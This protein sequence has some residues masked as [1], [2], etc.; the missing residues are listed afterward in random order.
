MNI[1]GYTD[2]LSYRPGETVHARFSTTAESFTARLVRLF[3][4][5][6]HPLGPGVDIR[7]VASPLDGQPAYPGRVQPIRA[8]SCLEIAESP[9]DGAGVHL[10]FWARPTLI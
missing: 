10:S 7:D 1:I 8:G 5:D 3:N 9:L 6:P 2:R 4:G